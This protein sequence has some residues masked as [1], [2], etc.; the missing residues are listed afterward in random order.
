MNLSKSKQLTLL[1]LFLLLTTNAFAMETELPE[2]HGSIVLQSEFYAGENDNT[3]G[4]IVPKDKFTVRE[5]A[6]EIEGKLNENI[7]YVIEIGNATCMGGGTMVQLMES[8]IY[9]K[10]NSFLKI[11]FIKGHIMR[12]FELR[13]ACAD[14]LTLEKPTF[15]KPF[16]PCCPTCFVLNMDYNISEQMSLETEFAFLNGVKGDFDTDRDIN[17]GMVFHTPLS[18]LALAGYYNLIKQDFEFD[19]DP[20]V[21]YRSSFGIDYDSNNILFRG[22]Y[23]LAKAFYS[24]PNDSLGVN[25]EELEMNAF[26][27]QGAYKFNT[28]FER[29]SYIQP[30]IKYEYWDKASNSDIEIE[31]T[32]LNA[33]ITFGLN[34]NTK[35]KVNY[36]TPLS[37]PDNKSDEADC[38]IIRLQTAF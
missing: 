22:E 14:V 6:I 23:Y 35:L 15:G 7:E 33:G 30:Y 38:V 11:G 4:Y 37:A 27:M 10:Y 12:G 19:N 29:L 16:P 2:I 26:Y 3:T 24:S 17:L 8:V 28:E 20:E 25:S 1:L 31:Y 32:Y 18:G 36:E 34:E 5:V 9:Y 13:A 21:G